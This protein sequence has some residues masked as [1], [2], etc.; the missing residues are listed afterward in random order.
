L[1]IENVK[2][3]I[4]EAMPHDKNNKA[5]ILIDKKY[6]SVLNL[7]KRNLI[8]FRQFSIFNFPF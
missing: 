3:K 1:K 7:P 8:K 6:N 2:C 5:M 4:V